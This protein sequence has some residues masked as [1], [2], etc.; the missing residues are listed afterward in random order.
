MG[1]NPISLAPALWCKQQHYSRTCMSL[2]DVY[3]ITWLL[4]MGGKCMFWSWAFE[5]RS[6]AC[7]LFCFLLTLLCGCG[8]PLTRPKR[9]ARPARPPVLAGPGTGRLAHVQ[10]KLGRP[11]ACMNASKVVADASCPLNDKIPDEQLLNLFSNNFEE[12]IV[13]LVHMELFLPR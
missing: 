4:H 8:M 2:W 11:Q 3:V 9:P 5:K 1:A 10:L 7:R 12:A 6:F 13:W